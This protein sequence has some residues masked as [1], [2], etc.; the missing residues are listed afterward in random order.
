MGNRSAKASQLEREIL[1]IVWL[2]GSVNKSQM[3]IDAQIQ[4]RAT[5]HDLRTFE[6]ETS[7]ELHLQSTSSPTAVVLIVSGRLGEP[8][9][10]KIH[11]CTHISAVYI[12][13]MNDEKHKIWARNFYKVNQTFPISERDIRICSSRFAVFLLI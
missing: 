7:C 6:E 4:L 13:C 5:F 2:D 11:R 1:P 12:F 8:F 10:P 9:V 3:N